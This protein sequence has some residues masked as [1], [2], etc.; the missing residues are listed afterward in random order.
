MD[1]IQ[2]RPLIV[3]VVLQKSFCPTEWKHMCHFDMRIHLFM[4]WRVTQ[5][6]F[7][8][9]FS[10]VINIKCYWFIMDYV[11][12]LDTCTLTGAVLVISVPSDGGHETDGC[13]DGYHPLKTMEGTSILTKWPSSV[14][15]NRAW[16]I[17]W[18]ANEFP[19][20]ETSKCLKQLLKN[21]VVIKQQFNF[22]QLIEINSLV[23]NLFR[24]VSF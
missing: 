9:C 8:C 22:M 21:K 24:P 20:P 19:V 14:K 23:L 16:I 18:L 4:I 6:L 1:R 12:H 13:Q 10:T 11:L 5:F 15:Y 17:L 7:L 2:M 3:R